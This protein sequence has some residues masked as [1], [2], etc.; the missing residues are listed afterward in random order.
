MNHRQCCHRTHCPMLKIETRWQLSAENLIRRNANRLEASPARCRPTKSGTKLEHCISLDRYGAL[1]S[2]LH[3]HELISSGR[4][5]TRQFYFDVPN[6]GLES[7]TQ[8]MFFESTQRLLEGTVTSHPTCV[9]A[10]SHGTSSL[11]CLRVLRD[12]NHRCRPLPQSRICFDSRH[13]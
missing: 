6:Q 9:F 10:N 11:R 7:Q 8:Y 5:A 13:N 2:N 12:P 3:S 1:Q 4:T